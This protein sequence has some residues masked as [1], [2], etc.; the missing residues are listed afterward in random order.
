[1]VNGKWAARTTNHERV[2]GT[3]M[4]QKENANVGYHGKP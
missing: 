4:E 2:S 1:M 3:E